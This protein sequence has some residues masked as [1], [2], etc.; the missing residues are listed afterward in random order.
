[1]RNSGFVLQ[2]GLMSLMT[3][4]IHFSAMVSWYAML[5]GQDYAR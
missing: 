1:M 5:G 4:I 3:V 2:K